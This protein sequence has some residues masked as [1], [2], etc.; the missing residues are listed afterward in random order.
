MA[1]SNFTGDAPGI[2]GS[3][4]WSGEDFVSGSHETETI[5]ETVFCRLQPQGT[6]QTAD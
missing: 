3:G 5:I 4:H 2:P 1:Q 6:A